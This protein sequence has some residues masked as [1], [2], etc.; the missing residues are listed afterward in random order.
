[1][2]PTGL[3][4]PIDS[5][6]LEHALQPARA[7]DAAALGVVAE[8]FGRLRRAFGSTNTLV[9]ARAVGMNLVAVDA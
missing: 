9:R 1:M 2:G 4:G 7:G 5:I 6:L 3:S 8:A